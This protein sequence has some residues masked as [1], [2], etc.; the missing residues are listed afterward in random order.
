MEQM[1]KEK[2]EAIKNSKILQ[3]FLFNMYIDRLKSTIEQKNGVIT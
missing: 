2:E 3:G 1:F